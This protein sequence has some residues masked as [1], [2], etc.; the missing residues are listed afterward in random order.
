MS[1]S[2]P[3]PFVTADLRVFIDRVV[4]AALL[5]RLLRKQA[6]AAAVAPAAARVASA[7]TLSSADLRKSVELRLEEPDVNPRGAARTS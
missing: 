7:V 5:E 4:V 6:A 2:Q 1:R 3:E